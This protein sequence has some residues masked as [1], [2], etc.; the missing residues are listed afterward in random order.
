[1]PAD[2]TPRGTRAALERL[3]ENWLERAE[4]A[5]THDDLIRAP[6]AVAFASVFGFLRRTNP[7]LIAS[8]E[9]NSARSA[10]ESQARRW[11]AAPSAVMPLHETLFGMSRELEREVAAFVQLHTAREHERMYSVAARDRSRPAAA[12]VSVEQRFTALQLAQRIDEVLLAECFVLECDGNTPLT[13]VGLGTSASVCGESFHS[14]EGW[15]A[16][17]SRSV[18]PSLR[19]TRWRCLP[20]HSARASDR[21]LIESASWVATTHARIR[22]YR[23]ECVAARA[24]AQELALQQQLESIDRARIENSERWRLIPAATQRQS[25]QK[26]RGDEST[27][28]FRALVASLAPQLAAAKARQP[29]G[30]AVHLEWTP[31]VGAQSASCL[32]VPSASPTEFQVRF[33][34]TA[35]NLDRSLDGV[36][37]SWMGCTVTISEAT[38]RFAAT[39]LRDSASPLDA[40]RR[41]GVLFVGSVPW[42][43][44]RDDEEQRA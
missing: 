33:F 9:W 5:I 37:A 32:L 31:E 6:R 17:M 3:L 18:D 23:T 14:I 10:I 28:V 7:R 19:S 39:Q 43:M 1:M 24:E 26:L 36:S 35:G 34:D 2:N 29:S 16:A 40:L 13:T 42:T 27:A 25:L 20:D 15:F 30:G 41:C 21:A 38:A 4:S 44:E 22:L 12:S 8:N 11:L